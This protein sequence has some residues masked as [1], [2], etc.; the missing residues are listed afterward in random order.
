MKVEALD[1]LE[2]AMKAV[3]N[4]VEAIDRYAQEIGIANQEKKVTI[5]DLTLMVAKKTQM[6]PMCVSRAVHAAFDM[7]RD[8]DLIVVAGEED[9]NE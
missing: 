1:V 6:D 7:I 9:E 2:N 3:N 8:L 4:A 5:E